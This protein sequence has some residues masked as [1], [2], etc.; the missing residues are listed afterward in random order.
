MERAVRVPKEDDFVAAMLG[1]QLAQET[2]V[3]E[4]GVAH[5]LGVELPERGSARDVG[6]HDRHLALWR[7]HSAL[8]PSR[9][10]LLVR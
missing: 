10:V 9:A 2:I 3:E 4:R 7:S 8:A 6:E 1:Q 5:G